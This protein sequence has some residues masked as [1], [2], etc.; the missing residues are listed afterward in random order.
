MSFACSE[1]LGW[2]PMVIKTQIHSLT[3]ATS[4]SVPTGPGTWW[5][6]DEY[7]NNE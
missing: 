6:P 2:I 5:R 4:S 3:S 1:T 7:T